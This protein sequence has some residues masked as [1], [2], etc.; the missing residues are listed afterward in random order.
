MNVDE[1]EREREIT[2]AGLDGPGSVLVL[3]P[4]IQTEQQVGTTRATSP[5]LRYSNLPGSFSIGGGVGT[6]TTP[7][8]GSLS[9]TA[10][11]L[12]RRSL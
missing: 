9:N 12:G 4:S 8:W 3:T 1:V 7:D 5:V 11:P 10:R 6:G 2:L